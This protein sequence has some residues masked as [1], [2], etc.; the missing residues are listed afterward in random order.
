MI[1]PIG[2]LASPVL[3]QPAVLFGVVRLAV[4][5]G[6]VLAEGDLVLQ[7]SAGQWLDLIDRPRVGVQRAPFLRHGASFTRGEWLVGAAGTGSNSA[8]VT[9]S[10][11][12]RWSASAMVLPG[13]RSDT[14]ASTL[15]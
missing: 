12:T 6:G 15:L 10:A 9:R 7:R 3:L 2:G 13:S 8:E 5:V 1:G 4:C 11:T 14:A